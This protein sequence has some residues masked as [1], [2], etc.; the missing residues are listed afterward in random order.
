MVWREADHFMVAQ[1]HLD[2]CSL[3]GDLDVKGAIIP[4][5]QFKHLRSLPMDYV[6]L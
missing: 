4:V 6:Q 2:A 3:R 5:V 1:I